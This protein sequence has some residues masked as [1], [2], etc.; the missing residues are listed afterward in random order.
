MDYSGDGVYGEQTPGGT[1]SGGFVGAG[2]LAPD[3][4][5]IV[6]YFLRTPTFVQFISV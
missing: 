4:P 3:N 1:A 5:E 2:G 6:S